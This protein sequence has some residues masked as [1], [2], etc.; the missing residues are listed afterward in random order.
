[1]GQIAKLF[2]AGG[3]VPVAA[4]QEPERKGILGF[5]GN[6]VGDVGEIVQGFGSLAGA[7]IHDAISA[8]SELFTLGKAETD[9]VLDDM[10]KALP[11]AIGKDYSERYGSWEGFLKGLYE[12]PLALV[13][14]AATIAT[15]G[16]YG[17]ARGAQVASKLPGVTKTIQAAGT[18]GKLDELTGVARAVDKILPGISEG[19]R[20]LAGTRKVVDPIGNVSAQPRALNPIR[21]V[22]QEKGLDKLLTEP[23]GNL[24]TREA[25]LNRNLLKSLQEHGEA[26]FP[27]RPEVRRLVER[28]DTDELSDAERLQRLQ[29]VMREHDITR[30]D[31]PIVSHFKLRKAAD[32]LFGLHGTKFIKERTAA[33]NEL[34]S[35]LDPLGNDGTDAV[36][37]AAQITTP[38]RAGNLLSYEDLRVGLLGE[39]SP[40][41][42][43]MVGD[44]LAGPRTLPSG[45]PV[46]GP[47][48][49]GG[50]PLGGT[51]TP[52]RRTFAGDEMEALRSRFGRGSVLED[53]RIIIGG[54]RE[55]ELRAREVAETL[56]GSLI[57]ESLDVGPYRGAT[58][59]IDRGGEQIRIRLQTD[60]A[61]RIT[62]A[63]AGVEARISSMDPV[64]DAEEIAAG[65]RWAENLSDP[66]IT[67][68]A[69]AAGR[70]V[71]AMQRAIDDL[72]L[73][74]HER[75]TEPLVDKGLLS[76]K[77][78][79]DR[80]YA[81]FW[82]VL[83]DEN[84]ERAARQLGRDVAVGEYPGLQLDDEMRRL[85]RK[86][87]VYFPQMDARRLKRSDFLLKWGTQ[88][89]LQRAEFMGGA[90]KKNLGG[91]IEVMPDGRWEAKYLT[92]PFEA[93]SRRASQVQGYLETLDI[94][95]D[96]TKQFGRPI[97]SMSEVGSSERAISLRS[98]KRLFQ[99][100][101][102]LEDRI[103]EHLGEGKTIKDAA[104]TALQDV[105]PELVDAS[106]AELRR[107]L[108]ALIRGADDEGSDLAA[109]MTAASTG[110]GDLW[111]VP[112]V[113]AD[114][115]DSF[116]KT[117]MGN[118]LVTLS[119]DT[120]TQAWR[121][122]VLVGSPRWVVNNL[123]GNIVF[124][125]MQGAKFSD[126]LMQ[127][128]SPKFRQMMDELVE[129]APENVR[130]D[131]ETA[132]F[133]GTT[134][135]RRHGG[136]A[137]ETRTG[138]A[139]EA[140]SDTPVARGAR[141]YGNK[142]RGANEK[143][144]IAFR[145]ASF[146][147]ALE[148]QAA[149]KSVGRMKRSFMR[150][151]RKLEQLMEGGLTQSEAEKALDQVNYFFNDYAAGTPIERNIIRRY[152]APF[153][154][155]YKHVT[156]LV[157]TYP[158]THPARAN[159]L[160]ML[161]E[162]SR[163]FGAE[164][165]PMPD[166]LEGAV[167]IG[168]GNKPGDTRFVTASGANPFNV[169]G[170]FPQSLVSA[171]HP[172]IQMG[173][174]RATGR[175]SFTG[176]PFT[177]PDVYTPFGS[178]QQF[179]VDPETMQAVPVDQVTPGFLEQILQQVPQYNVLRDA[180]RVIQGEEVGRRYSTGETIEDPTG[181]PKYPMD[182]VQQLGK[183]AGIPTTD[184]NLASYQQR[185]SDDQQAALRGYLRQIG[186]L[187]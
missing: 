41:V 44:E 187:A 105:L 25:G 113:V 142:V 43:A 72:R 157:L 139:L 101:T 92:D 184:Y 120:A 155:F 88:N 26:I 97:N 73:F 128:I 22:F 110:E 168:E 12:D 102:K 36:H 62:D 165:G 112:K 109:A 154:P 106:G 31:R 89:M 150:S 182:F 6:V 75:L 177:A 96:M 37:V 2:G 86:S 59:L 151:N 169:L 94:V 95:T 173:L 19:S 33:F 181:A 149:T 175:D 4:V 78:A 68:V 115:I 131:L 58:A 90:L 135:F 161:T 42:G 107:L 81:A 5:L 174:E 87:P 53:G 23:I 82:K 77:R 160:R 136:R 35:I 147:S 38:E 137:S 46:D 55:A 116:H 166:W 24:A 162:M 48:Y 57:E 117:R 30:I 17:A 159:V 132:F 122:A 170:D 74:V 83:P 10:A 148:R 32:S 100:R 76:Y 54:V 66:L 127:G 71:S 186:L 9:F 183:L 144:E 29:N 164:L 40:L 176:Q 91:L 52:P 121:S 67:E 180:A 152:I 179:R 20:F 1:M 63:V 21:R 47:V 64:E 45:E 119:W 80:S 3:S 172:V 156:K 56:G 85:G 146:K 98:V 50:P 15:L 178:D 133:S 163:E 123:L 60:R 69:E 138:Q 185:L 13:G 18:A 130:A 79:L 140:L 16:G 125:K 28:I 65:R 124:L 39:E 27:N 93:Y 49:P 8:G 84:K 126:V 167:P 104:E 70:E 14:D 141:W 34:K 143:L 51:L 114:R 108:P 158:A 11:G 103:I 99:S 153:Y 171:T 145:R 134:Q 118:N 7:G 61:R 129:A 111:A